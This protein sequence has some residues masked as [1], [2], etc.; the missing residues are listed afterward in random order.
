MN[1]LI[2]MENNALCVS[3]D[4]RIK[5]LKDKNQICKFCS[6]ANF[7]TAHSAIFIMQLFFFQVH[8]TLKLG[9]SVKFG[10]N[11]FFKYLLLQKNKHSSH[12]C[13]PLWPLSSRG[14]PLFLCEERY[15]VLEHQWVSHTFDHI[16]KRWGPHY[17]GL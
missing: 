5:L 11:S 8:K 13:Y 1:V 12:S 3:A 6:F 9:S 10:H 7:S 14:K 15:R 16:N 2:L 4:F 17:N